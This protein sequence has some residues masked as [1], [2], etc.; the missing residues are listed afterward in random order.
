ME[1]ATC[2]LAAA[3]IGEVAQSAC[4]SMSTMAT[5]PVMA[6]MPK[7]EAADWLAMLLMVRVPVVSHAR[8]IQN[9]STYFR[10]RVPPRRSP[11]T[12]QV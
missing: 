12:P 2:L 8:P 9:S 6:W 1:A 7:P 5:T 11:K 4:T 3:F 10:L